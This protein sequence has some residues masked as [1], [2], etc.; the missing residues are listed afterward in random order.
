MRLLAVECC[1]PLAKL[2]GKEDIVQH[3]LP[4]VQK[5]S[6]VCRESAGPTV[7]DSRHLAVAPPVIG[8]V[9]F[10]ARKHLYSSVAI[11]R[12]RTSLGEY[13]TTWRSS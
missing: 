3:I 12:R 9:L 11:S 1:G 6:Q 2:C 10:V 13:A 5:F 8:V 4:V 7:L